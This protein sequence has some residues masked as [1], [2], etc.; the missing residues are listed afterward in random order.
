MSVIGA[1]LLLNLFGISRG[2]A[3]FF[4]PMKD[5]ARWTMAGTPGTTWQ[6][7]LFGAAVLLFGAAV[8]AF[9]DPV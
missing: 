8:I 3:G 7:R 5:E 9:A 4:G 6:W 2:L 1:A